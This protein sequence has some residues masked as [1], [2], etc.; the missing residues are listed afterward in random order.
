[1]QNVGA[2]PRKLIGII[3]IALVLGPASLMLWMG[4]WR[5]A[6]LY[7]L[8]SVCAIGVLFIFSSHLTATK[9]GLFDAFSVIAL[10]LS[11]IGLVHAIYIRRSALRR[12]WYSRWYVALPFPLVATF[13]LLVPMFGMRTFF[14]QPFDMPSA[15]MYP[16]LKVGD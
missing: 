5:A 4:R 7:V 9:L 16:T 10:T 11:V 1:M 8:A 3:V 2:T 6:L 12:P 15:S 13:A 14:Y